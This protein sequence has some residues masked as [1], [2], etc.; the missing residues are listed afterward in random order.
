MKPP[1]YMNAA[2]NPEAFTQRIVKLSDELF[3]NDIVS[4]L[5]NLWKSIFELLSDILLHLSTGIKFNIGNLKNSFELIHF[6]A[7]GYIY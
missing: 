1:V 2:S 6:Y 7:P 4:K 5:V 3:C